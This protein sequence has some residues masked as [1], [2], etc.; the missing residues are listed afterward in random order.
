M[1]LDSARDL[2]RE[3]LDRIVNPIATRTAEVRTDGARALRSGAPAL[4]GEDA[5]FEGMGAHTLATIPDIQR[6]LA[7]GVAPFQRRDYRLAIRLQRPALR[8]SALVT[9][10]MQ[11]AR[12]EVDVRL[13]GRIDKRA[14]APRPPWYRLNTR[15][16][17]IG[18]SV[19]HG[20]V[21]AGTIGAFV[22]RGDETCVLSNNH[23]LANEDRAAAGD[24]IL[25]RARFD[26]GKL[27]TEAIARLGARVRLKRRA[28][29]EVDAALAVLKDG[30]RHD[31]RLLR[32][33]A[34]GRDRR[35]NGLGPEFIDE[36]S[37]VY[38]IGRTTGAT[39][40]RVTA[41]DLDNVV[42]NYEIGN[43]RFDGQ[44]EIEGIGAQ[45]FSDGGDSGA[46]IVNSRMQA[47]ALLFA[48]SDTGGRRGG[49]LT[50]AN[51]IH[52]VLADL[53]AAL[54]S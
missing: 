20:M 4:D 26:G 29:N 7:L 43:L 9:H 10:L 46:L 11:Q 49:G 21:T 30:V 15:P 36:G 33:I 51:P 50:F 23:V 45:P 1:R 44:I 18:A 8:D 25:Q 16:L 53:G 34:A 12:G 19:G 6:T 52:R 38:K 48:G 27:R 35:L 32:A 22:R 40:G 41:F 37:I 39:K 2:K 24:A 14:A 28:A 17:L 3:L 42:V 13:V 54:L 31:A 47:V 5:A